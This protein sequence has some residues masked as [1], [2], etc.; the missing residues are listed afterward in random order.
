VGGAHTSSAPL[1]ALAVESGSTICD[2]PTPNRYEVNLLLFVVNHIDHEA[3]T[4]RGVL[5]GQRRTFT[6]SA[7]TPRLRRNTVREAEGGLESLAVFVGHGGRTGR[8]YV[9]D[10][11]CSLGPDVCSRRPAGFSGHAATAMA[12]ARHKALGGRLG[13]AP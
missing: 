4:L 8:R 3:G 10:P 12:L 2:T 1:A 5:D 11:V 13:Y 9:S 6:M 7:M